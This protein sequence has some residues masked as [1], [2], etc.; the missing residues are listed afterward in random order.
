M[1]RARNGE[2]DALQR[3]QAGID[4]R[5]ILMT[6]HQGAAMAGDVLDHRADAAL[7]QAVHEGFGQ[8]RDGVRR[9]TESAV[10][11]DGIGTRLRYVQNRRAIDGH[12]NVRQFMG[13]QAAAQMTGFEPPLRVLGVEVRIRLGG[14][15]FG[16]VG[17]L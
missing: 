9:L 2:I 17:R 16:P 14:G 10:A 5:Q 3:L 11:D 7:H 15:K 12:A 4:H 13:D 6:V 8:Y 1:C